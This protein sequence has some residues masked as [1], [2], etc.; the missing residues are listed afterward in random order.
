MEE[1]GY[2][3]SYIDIYDPERLWFCN[4]PPMGD[5]NNVD[6]KSIYDNLLSR[7]DSSLIMDTSNVEYFVELVIR[8]Y[9]VTRKMWVIIQHSPA[10]MVYQ[11]PHAPVREIHNSTN[12]IRSIIGD[13]AVIKQLSYIGSYASYSEDDVAIVDVMYAET[14]LDLQHTLV[15][16]TGIRE[17]PKGY[18]ARMQSEFNGFDLS[19]ERWRCT[20]PV[21]ILIHAWQEGIMSDCILDNPDNT[22]ENVDQ[23]DDIINDDAKYSAYERITSIQNLLGEYIGDFNKLVDE[24]KDL[25]KENA[26]LCTQIEELNAML[27]ESQEHRISAWMHNIN[28]QMEMLNERFKREDRKDP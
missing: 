8:A 12:Y 7:L 26:R 17:L 19:I 4:T 9:D 18:V 1:Q 22:F 2:K 5:N 28:I 25:W 13:D 14:S 21:N 11:F 3:K 24:N 23:V 10:G 20:A 16:N 15:N 6:Q 27:A